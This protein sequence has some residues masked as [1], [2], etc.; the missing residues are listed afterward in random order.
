[1]PGGITEVPMPGRTVEVPMPGPAMEESTHKD[2]G[3]AQHTIAAAEAWTTI[4][5]TETIEWLAGSVRAHMRL[6]RWWK[7][8]S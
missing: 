3:Q 4:T 5:I 6:R 8:E 2:Q 7:G 1:M